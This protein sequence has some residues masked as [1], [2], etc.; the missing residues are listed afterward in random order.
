MAPLCAITKTL[1]Q[2]NYCKDSQ[3]S[4]ID[5][6]FSL[7][8]STR[9][10][11]PLFIKQANKFHPMIKFKISEIETR[12]LDTIIIKGIDSETTLYLT[13]VL[14]TS[15]LKQFSKHISPGVT[16]QA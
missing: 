11:I 2:S 3:I 9:Q 8:D 13:S 1:K 10:E 6:I 14:T 15:L 16:H 4:H 12:F 5:N 7:R